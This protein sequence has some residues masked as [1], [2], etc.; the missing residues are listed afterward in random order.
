MCAVFMY[1]YPRTL[2]GGQVPW[3]CGYN[4]GFPICETDWESDAVDDV[5]NLG[6]LF[7]SVDDS[8]VCSQPENG[9]TEA[10][11]P[12]SESTSAAGLMEYASLSWIMMACSPFFLV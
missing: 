11:I 1:Y 2:I 10:P 3:F 4:V 12:S 8:R 5:D 7:G 6:R 9:E